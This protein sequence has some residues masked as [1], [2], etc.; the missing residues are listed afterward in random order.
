MNKKIIELIV[1]IVLIAAAVCAIKFMGI[2]T[3]II[4]LSTYAIGRLVGMYAT[5]PEI[6]EKVVEK[7]VEVPAKS[8]KN[9]KVK[10]SEN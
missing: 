5:E 6:I 4:A 9:K 3:S 10:K 8:P 7:I 2:W 1:T